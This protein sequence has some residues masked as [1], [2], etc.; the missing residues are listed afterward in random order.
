M[1]SPRTSTRRHSLEP[2]PPTGPIPRQIRRRN[3][4]LQNLLSVGTAARSV[5]RGVG[6]SSSYRSSNSS[7]HPVRRRNSLLQKTQS[8]WAS[9]RSLRSQSETAPTLATDD[10]DIAT[11]KEVRFARKARKRRI[12][13]IGDMDQ[14]EIEG[15]WYSVDEREKLRADARCSA[16]DTAAR[17]PQLVKSLLKGTKGASFVA[18]SMQRDEIQ[19][20]LNEGIAVSKYVPCMEDW[21]QSQGSRGLEQMVSLEVRR[22]RSQVGTD[23]RCVIVQMSR[24]ES[25]AGGRRDP[26]RLAQV[27]IDLTRSATV[28]ARLIAIADSLAVLDK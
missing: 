15:T 18:N 7:P 4:L 1:Q 2:M 8:L 25:R 9:A 10:N 23:S 22:K 6:R 19:D 21:C 5:T 13:C 14:E 28:L 26:V 3:S 11:K 17:N 20:F 12:P 27:Y 24:C 16:W